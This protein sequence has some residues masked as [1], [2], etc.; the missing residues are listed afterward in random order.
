MEITTCILFFV[1]QVVGWG[2]QPLK[3]ILNNHRGLVVCLQ[4]PVQFFLTWSVVANLP[5]NGVSLHL[6]VCHPGVG[7]CVLQMVRKFLGIA[8]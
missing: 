6:G 4:Y 3:K 5:N 2:P 7:I 8:V 1:C